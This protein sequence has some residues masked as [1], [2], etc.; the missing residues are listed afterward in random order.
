MFG[1]VFND[2]KSMFNTIK[3][4][5]K[6]KKKTQLVKKIKIKALLKVEKPKNGK[7]AILIK[8]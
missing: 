4:H 6:R 3:A 8:A 2:L 7:N 1:I 5:L